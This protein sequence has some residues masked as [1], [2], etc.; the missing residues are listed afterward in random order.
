MVEKDPSI[1][2]EIDVVLLAMIAEDMG[3]LRPQRAEAFLSSFAEEPDLEGSY[4]L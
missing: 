4:Q 2:A 3:S 1:R